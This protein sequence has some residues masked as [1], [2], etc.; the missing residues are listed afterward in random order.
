M[1]IKFIVS[2]KLKNEARVSIWEI[3][4][5][6]FCTAFQF[7]NKRTPAVFRDVNSTKSRQDLAYGAQ[8][9]VVRL[10]SNLTDV[11]QFEDQR[12]CPP[13]LSLLQHREKAL[14]A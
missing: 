2:Y 1:H 3:D 8:E 7:Q 6:S 14:T 12:T 10:S 4:S 9:T 5:S 11:K 13:S